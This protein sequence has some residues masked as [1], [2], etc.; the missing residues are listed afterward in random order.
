MYHISRLRED[1]HAQ[2]DVQD[3][4]RSMSAQAKKVMPLTFALLCGKDKYNETYS[5]IYGQLPKVTEAVLPGARKV[6]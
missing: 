1:A 5:H 6:K 4:S 3:I 2:W